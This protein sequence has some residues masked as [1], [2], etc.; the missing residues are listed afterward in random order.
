MA[1][2]TGT[3]EDFNKFINPI[4]RN[5]V[6]NMSRK[7]K[8]HTTCSN[9]G[10]N[11]RTTLQAAHLSGKERPTIVANIICEMMNKTQIDKY[12]I[13]DVD[14]NLFLQKFIEEHTP[15]E[16][17]VRILCRECHIKYD[18]ENKIEFKDMISVDDTE[19]EEATD[20]DFEEAVLAA[21]TT[22]AKKDIINIADKK[23]KDFSTNATCFFAN[24]NKTKTVWW[25]EPNR[26]KFLGS[27]MLLNNADK[28][29]VHIFRI[30]DDTF[31]NK[32]QIRKDKNNP[33]RLEIFTDKAPDNF[34]EKFSDFDFKKFYVQT[35]KY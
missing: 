6:A 26:E 14:L 29:E 21:V 18:K 13:V 33:Y 28:K 25:V 24:V 31:L 22:K 35:I 20:V 1:H 11:K 8:K 12:D 15:L 16:K 7:A 2:F 27:W 9:S 4:T 23:I 32:L 30:N 3:F 34:K 17:A 10:C 19:E 5:L